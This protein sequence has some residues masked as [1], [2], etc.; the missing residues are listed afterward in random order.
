[1]IND[2]VVIVGAKRTAHGKMLG[3]LTSVP[4]SQLA[5]T[6]LIAALEP[7]EIPKGDIDEVLLGCVLPAGQ[8]QAPARQAAIKAGLPQSVGATTLSK[9]CGSGMKAVMFA[10][11][12]LRAGN[13]HI[14]AA[15]GM[16]N[17]SAA[18]HLLLDARKGY[19]L[20]HRD[21]KDHMFFDGLED[22]YEPGK[23][24]GFFADETAKRY[25]FSR[26]QQDDFAIESLRRAQAAAQ[27]GCFNDEIAP[28][29]IKKRKETLQFTQD[30]GPLAAKIENIPQL[31]PAFQPEGTVTAANSSSI[32][33]GAAALILMRLS[34]AERRGI[35]PL[36][37]ILDHASHAQEPAWFTTA[38]VTAI[39]KLL[40]KVKWQP[41]DVDLYE[42]NEAFAVVTMVA[43]RD[44]ELSHECVN[45]YG[46]ACAL[47]HPIGAT[48]ARIMV[49]LLHALRQKG[50]RRGV[51]SL[52]IGGGGS[53]G[54][55]NRID[56]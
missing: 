12:M 44:L 36:A 48:G 5:A 45:V 19:R 29:T 15:G 18:P 38:P 7:L 41:N 17:M 26:Q 35:T 9:M 27:A 6:A 10:H 49:T 14:Y 13:G 56:G 55:C 22:V 51:A 4:A 21:I 25:E 2:P 40:N 34:E 3:G 42:I 33:D 8:G 39:Q 50:L 20:G 53:N 46:G 52:C 11:D 43:M 30:E 47:G 28:V 24:M 32:A 1:M 54:H 23:L 31:R 16:E 37:K